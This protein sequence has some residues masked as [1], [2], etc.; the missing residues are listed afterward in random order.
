MVIL[1]LWDSSK[2]FW[3]LTGMPL[4]VLF[5]FA[6]LFISYGLSIMYKTVTLF[7]DMGAGTLAPW[8]ATE[9][10]VTVGLYAYM[11]NPM[12]VG[13]F[14]VQLGETAIFGSPGVAV[15]VAL[16][17]LTNIV[18][19]PVF[20]EPGLEERFGQEYVRYKE[21]VPRWIPRRDPWKGS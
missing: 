11:R 8:D 16:F 1:Y 6:L 15:W 17:M 13:I 10:L 3:G 4:L 21:N 14:I 5:A 12:I 18:Y 7:A 19:I 20:E 9:H 2:P